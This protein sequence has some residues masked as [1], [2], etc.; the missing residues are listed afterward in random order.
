MLHIRTVALFHCMICFWQIL[1]QQLHAVIAAS[2]SIKNSSKIRKLI[3]VHALCIVYMI[4][5][6]IEWQYA[7]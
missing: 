2:V 4:F 6:V 1:L 7:A 3:E 5:A